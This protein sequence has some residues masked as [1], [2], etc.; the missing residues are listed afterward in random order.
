[1]VMACDFLECSEG[2]LPFKY[3]GLPVGANSRNMTTWDS[4]TLSNV[5]TLNYEIPS[6]RAMGKT[7][8]DSKTLSHVSLFSL[9]TTQTF[10]LLEFS[11]DLLHLSQVPHS[12][13][14]LS[15]IDSLF[16]PYVPICLLDSLL[17]SSIDSFVLR[18]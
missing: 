2:A 9:F 7:C 17:L 13:F 16:L 4:T 14:F 12:Q 18:L 8:H 15:L 10:L 1:M 3:F 11:L 5:G 6:V